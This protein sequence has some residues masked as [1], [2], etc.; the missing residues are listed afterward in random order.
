MRKPRI[1]AGDMF[2]PNPGHAPTIPHEYWPVTYSCRTLASL[3]TRLASV[4]LEARRIALSDQTGSNQ[5]HK[6]QVLELAVGCCAGSLSR[7]LLITH[8]SSQSAR[9]SWWCCGLRHCDDRCGA[10]ASLQVRRCLG[11]AIDIRAPDVAFS[12]NYI[13]INRQ[14]GKRRLESTSL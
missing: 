2:M 13:T 8:R 14:E 1:L 10:A 12:G 6:S 3:R 7:A 5:D 9:S 4:L 11:R